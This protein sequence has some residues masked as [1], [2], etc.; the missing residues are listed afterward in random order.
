MLRVFWPV[1][2]AQ[3]AD[4][5]SHESMQLKPANHPASREIFAAKKVLLDVTCHQSLQKIYEMYFRRSQI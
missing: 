1:H 5:M 4:D 2:A 3:K